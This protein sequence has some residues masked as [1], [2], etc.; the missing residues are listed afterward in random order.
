MGT[1]IIPRKMRKKKRSSAMTREKLRMH[2]Y[3]IVNKTT[4]LNK[5]LPCIGGPPGTN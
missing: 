5:L 3:Q 2:N 4:N 1:G